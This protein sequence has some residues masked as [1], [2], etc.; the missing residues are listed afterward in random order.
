MGIH[1]CKVCKREF[2][3]KAS[4]NRK[5]CDSCATE[6][7]ERIHNKQL[8]ICPICGKKIP[9]LNKRYT[10]CSK[11]CLKLGNLVLNLT[12]RSGVQ[13][14]KSKN[15]VPLDDIALEA[16]EHGMHYGEYIARKDNKNGY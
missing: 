2:D 15:R 1:K 8:G 16:R 13:Y 3:A 5:I 14:R 12:N 11:E 6:L 9:I 10:Y 4:W 7:S